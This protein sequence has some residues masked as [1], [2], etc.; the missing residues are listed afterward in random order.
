MGMSRETGFSY[1]RR[2]CIKLNEGKSQKDQSHFP[3][4]VSAS[5][6]CIELSIKA[7]FHF[8][9]VEYPRKHNVFA[10]NFK[11]VLEKIHI[12]EE[13]Y[14][15]KRVIVL[16]SPE[17]PSN[18]I[19][20]RETMA[21]HKSFKSEDVERLFMI[22]ELWGLLY[23]KA[24]YGY[25]KLAIPS[26]RLFRKNEASLALEHAYEC[27]R[28]AYD[29][30]YYCCGAIRVQA[31]KYPIIK[32]LSKPSFILNGYDFATGHEEDIWTKK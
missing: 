16:R 32:Y 12:C 29:V 2:A 11:E 21:F 13:K 7:I 6:E 3:E 18:Q 23:L 10:K 8:T 31:Y 25:E 19:E 15:G 4:A 9:G 14:T 20:E 24:K 26:E 1:M 30:Y 22:S 17:G 5:Q 28:V 27:Y